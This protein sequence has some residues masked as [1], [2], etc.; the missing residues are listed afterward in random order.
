MIA[1]EHADKMKN[2]ITEIQWSWDHPIIQDILLTYYRA[3]LFNT[4]EI[5]TNNAFFLK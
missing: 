3:W 1:P 2:E 4:P 5:A